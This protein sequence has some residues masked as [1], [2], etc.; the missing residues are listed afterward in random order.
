MKIYFTA[1]GNLAI[2]FSSVAQLCLTLYK[3]MNLQ[4]ARPLLF[5]NNFKWSTIYKNIES[6]CCIPKTNIILYINYTSTKNK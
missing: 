5:Y 4:H 1:Q 6:L 3:P 2:Q